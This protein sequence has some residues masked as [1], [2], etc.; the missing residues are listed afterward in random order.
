MTGSAKER[1]GSPAF[2]AGHRAEARLAVFT[3]KRENPGFMEIIILRFKAKS[4][5][6]ANA[7]TRLS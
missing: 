1:G 7:T 5:A 2:K 3:G 4:E 6:Q